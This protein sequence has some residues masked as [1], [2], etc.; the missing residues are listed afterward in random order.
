MD[1]R[2][3]I[4]QLKKIK[5][6]K[7]ITYNAIL[8]ALNVNGAPVLSLTMLRRVFAN[9]S[10]DKASSF[11]YEQ[12]LIPIA[13]AMRKIAGPEDDPNAKEIESLNSMI[14]VQ[15]DAIDRLI[16]TKEQL[17]SSVNFFSKQIT[18]KDALITRLID[19]LDQKDN[20]IQQFITDLRQKDEI[21]KHLRE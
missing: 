5:K 6:A 17:I 13:E 3:M 4:L 14:R 16:A 7:N 10:E 2:E 19:R 11:S 20:I 9:G 12:T 18:E 21:I 15:G 1:S 8:D